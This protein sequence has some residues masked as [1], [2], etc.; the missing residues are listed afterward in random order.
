MKKI[1]ILA[2]VLIIAMTATAS[3]LT[4][5]T[6]SALLISRNINYNG[7]VSSQEF[8]VY[9][10]KVYVPLRNFGNLTGIS[11]EYNN[12]VIYLKDDKVKIKND[13][14]S[15]IPPNGNYIGEARAKE[16]ALQNAGVKEADVT[17][18]KVKLD[19]DDKG[20]VYEIEFFSNNMVHEYE[21][22]IN[23]VTGEIINH[24]EALED[25]NE[26]DKSDDKNMNN[27]NTS[28]NYIGNDKAQQIALDNAG[29]TRDQVNSFKIEL[30]RE[31]GGW[32][33]K[34]EFKY[35]EKE[36]EYKINATNGSIIE[37]SIDD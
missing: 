7:N 34:V 16:I 13:D 11:T 9:N 24:T 17:F 31:D 33:Y 28:N 21:Y 12:G 37:K 5:K 20:A 3:A 10:D 35:G 32:E 1:S 25:S 8:I 6:I 4:Y 22:E 30:E 29:L 36:Y 19:M 14:S 23:A 2:V 18:K 15:N 27:Q 26:S